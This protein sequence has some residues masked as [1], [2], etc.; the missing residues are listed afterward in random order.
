MSRSTRLA[1]SAE[2]EWV[3]PS[4]IVAVQD[5]VRDVQDALVSQAT[6][7]WSVER[8]EAVEDMLDRLT[9]L[10]RDLARLAG[11]EDGGGGSRHVEL[12]H[13]RLELLVGGGRD[14]IDLPAL[15]DARRQS[16]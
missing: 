6:N 15:P 13:R 8:R 16:R 1:S 7:S 12:L 4:A 11:Y 10:M 5:L 9:V 3:D 14:V 2:W